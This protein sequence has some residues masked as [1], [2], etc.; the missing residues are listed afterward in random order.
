MEIWIWLGVIVVLGIIELSTVQLICIWFIVGALGSMIS[1]MFGAS[2]GIQL[3]IFVAVSAL[4]L[5]FTRPIAIKALTPKKQSFNT[6]R[7]IGKIGVVI[8]D[9]SNIDAKGQVKVMGSVWSARSEDGS[10]I[11]EGTSVKVVRI[12]GVK[13]LVVAIDSEAVGD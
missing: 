12:E 6:D 11:P 3:G 10:D 5:I 8:S 13:L 4:M 1:A 9:I 2:I 7:N